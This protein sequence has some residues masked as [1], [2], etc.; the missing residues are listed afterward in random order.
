MFDTIL[1][2]WIQLI[3]MLI[4]EIFNNTRIVGELNTKWGHSMKEWTKCDKFRDISIGKLKL[5]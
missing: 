3:K 4:K 2:E 1:K 5:G